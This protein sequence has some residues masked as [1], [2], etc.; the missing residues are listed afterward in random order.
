M[1]STSR[2]PDVRHSIDDYEYDDANNVVI[3]LTAP[4]AELETIRELTPGELFEFRSAFLQPDVT[5]RG[6]QVLDSADGPYD[7]LL[8]P[9]MGV[10]LQETADGH[11]H[12]FWIKKLV[13]DT[14]GAIFMQGMLIK[15]HRHV[16]Y[17]YSERL[18][19]A[20]H[21]VLPL[22]KNDVAMQLKSTPDKLGTPLREECLE[23]RSVDEV[24]S[25]REI[26]FTNADPPK[27]Y[28]PQPHWTHA[29]EYGVLTCRWKFTEEFEGKKPVGYQIARLDPAECDL[30]KG[31]P[32]L[33]WRREYGKVQSIDHAVLAVRAYTYADACAGAGGCIVGASDAGLTPVWAIDSWDVAINTLRENW[34]GLE[35][36]QIEIQD[37]ANRQR[38]DNKYRVDV[39]HISFP[40]QGFS[41]LNRGVNP[42]RDAQNNDTTLCLGKMLTTYRPRILTLEQTTGILSSR[43]DQIYFRKLID[44][45]TSSGYSVRWKVINMQNLGVS[46]ARKRLMVVAACPGQELP[47]FPAATHGPEDGLKPHVSLGRAIAAIPP[48]ATDHDVEAQKRNFAIRPLNRS[49]ANVNLPHQHLITT[50]GAQFLLRDGGR[51]YAPTIRQ[52]MRL[53]TFPD[54]YQITGTKT[55][56]YKQ[57]GNAV[58]C[59]FMKQIFREVG[60]TLEKSDREAREWLAETIDLTQT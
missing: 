37:F 26:I 34:Y 9:G 2:I 18:G 6:W 14:A 36:E 16:F 44:Q 60:N 25:E 21:A 39:L 17:K 38:T 56:A 5:Q 58:P 3:D 51:L 50:A 40:C 15:R 27:L 49:E 47:P 32:D 29:E 13:Q 1:V 22:R 28:G 33:Y 11:I 8:R 24:E 46:Q 12:Y 59:T 7:I 31:L 57:I 41:L 20:L 52:N 4:D 53:Q 43:Q 19:D 30:N 23:L 55:D 54:H 45:I 35:L 10:Q 48:W 42:V